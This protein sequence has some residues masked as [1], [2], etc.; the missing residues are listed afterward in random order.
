VAT[1]DERVINLAFDGLRRLR[2][3]TVYP[4]WP[5]KSNPVITEYSYD[6]NGQTGIYSFG[7]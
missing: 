6:A 5:D 1:P 7:T 4:R 2:R 3:M